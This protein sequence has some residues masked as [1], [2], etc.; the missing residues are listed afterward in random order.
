MAQVYKDNLEEV[1]P[2]I[3]AA[4]ASCD[5]M[6]LDFEMSGISMKDKRQ[7]PNYN[8]SPQVG[9]QAIDRTR[10]ETKMKDMSPREKVGVPVHNCPFHLVS[11]ERYAKMRKVVNEYSI[12]QMGLCTFT[13]DGLGAKRKVLARPFNMYAFPASG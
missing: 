13:K 9:Q 12:I 11:Q 4:I 5:F 10:T 6:A 3:E 8:D 2:D 7:H 1:L